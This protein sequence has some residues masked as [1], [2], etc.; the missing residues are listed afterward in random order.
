MKLIFFL[1]LI[2]LNL[3]EGKDYKVLGRLSKKENQ[4][5]S[6]NYYCVYIDTSEFEK[7]DKISIKITVYSGSFDD[8]TLYYGY[9][10]TEPI[11]EEYAKAD[12]QKSP[13]SHDCQEQEAWGFT[14]YYYYYTN[15][16]KVPKSSERYLIVGIPEFSGHLK[17][18]VELE[19][20]KW[21]FPIW[22][23]VILV[24][25]GIGLLFL[26]LKY[27][28]GRIKNKCCSKRDDGPSDLGIT[29]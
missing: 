5:T 20:S 10:D 3:S 28:Y 21:I 8:S 27:V 24:L 15:L 6:K 23:K 12:R 7:D 26:L 13:D 22:L 25:V 9:S 16:Y 4:E 1:I 17:Y 19:I 11:V 18:Y 2:L 14:I 29:E